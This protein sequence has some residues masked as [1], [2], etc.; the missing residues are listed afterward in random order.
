MPYRGKPREQPQEPVRKTE[1][2]SEMVAQFASPYAFAR[3][4]VQNSID[5][6]AKRISVSLDFD[7]VLCSTHLD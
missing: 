6:P 3:E 5:A 7:G 4:F 2:V 1:L